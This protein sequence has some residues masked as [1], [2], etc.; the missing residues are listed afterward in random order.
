[1]QDS[2]QNNHGP[3]QI[4]ATTPAPKSTIPNPPG[5]LSNPLFHPQVR[6][7]EL[8]KDAQRAVAA[9]TANK[10][11]RG[12][13]RRF[14]SVQQFTTVEEDLSTFDLMDTLGGGPGGAPGSQQQQGQQAAPVGGQLQDT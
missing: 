3:Y 1:M 12:T 13:A 8:T 9:Q 10:S 2:I 14:N 11:T 6:A 4:R 5:P 7:A